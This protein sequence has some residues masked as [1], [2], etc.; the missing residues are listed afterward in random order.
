MELTSKEKEAL[1]RLLKD[2]IAQID[3]MVEDA[4]EQDKLSLINFQETLKGILNKI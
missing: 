4:D 2:E 1:E 3:E